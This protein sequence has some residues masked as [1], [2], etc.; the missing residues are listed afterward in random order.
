MILSTVTSWLN[1]VSAVKLDDVTVLLEQVPLV[2]G[3][4]EQSLEDVG[5]II[6]H[7]VV[8]IRHRENAQKFFID[9]YV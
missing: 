8:N 6:H 9:S 7:R 3:L 1:L 5:I 4:Y 2:V